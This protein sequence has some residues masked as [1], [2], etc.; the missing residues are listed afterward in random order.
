MALSC[1]YFGA[2]SKYGVNKYYEESSRGTDDVMVTKA[3]DAWSSE[4]MAWERE[5]SCMEACQYTQ[6]IER[7]I[8]VLK[9]E[10]NII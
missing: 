7:N 6:V 5:P 2:K 9:C 4:R 10:R 8:V 1:N 3:I